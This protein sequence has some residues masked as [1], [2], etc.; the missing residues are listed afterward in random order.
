MFPGL[1]MNRVNDD[2]PERPTPFV[3]YASYIPTGT[4]LNPVLTNFTHGGKVDSCVWPTK[5]DNQYYELIFRKHNKKW[6][7]I[8]FYHSM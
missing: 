8:F 5:E 2:I 1:I 3:E 7:I 6:H 4:M